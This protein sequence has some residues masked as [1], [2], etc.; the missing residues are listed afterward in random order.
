MQKK[1]TK[2]NN[3]LIF[4][5]FAVQTMRESIQTF[6]TALLD[7]VRTSNELDIILNYDPDPDTEPWEPGERPTLERLKL[8]IKCKLKAVSFFFLRGG[9]KGYLESK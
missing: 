7:Q 5:S 8:A 4:K 3:E 1:K 2:K 9:G 6:S